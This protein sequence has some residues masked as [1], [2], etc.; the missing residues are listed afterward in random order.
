ML[1]VPLKVYP[2]RQSLR[3][4]LTIA[5]LCLGLATAGF[6][7]IVNPNF[8]VA[9]YSLAMA[10]FA[11]AM[12]NCIA[13]MR[14]QPMIKILDDRFPVYTPFGSVRSLFYSTLRIEI[15]R[16]ARPRWSSSLGRLLYAVL[17][18]NFTNTIT[19]PGFLLGADPAAVIQM[20]EKRRL[21]A[22]RLEA[23]GDYDPTALTSVG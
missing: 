7:T 16:S 12:L 23:I 3:G 19:I 15:N 13:V 22:V 21:A 10:W 4:C 6:H 14:R 20:L 8:R 17:G 11:T 1:Y 5:V 9:L 2:N 18:L